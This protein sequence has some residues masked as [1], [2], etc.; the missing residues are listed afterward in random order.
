MDYSS[1]RSETHVFDNEGLR[2]W[3]A[4]GGGKELDGHCN[5]AKLQGSSTWLTTHIFVRQ[6]A[7]LEV[8]TRNDPFGAFET[9]VH[10]RG[11]GC[12]RQ[13]WGRRTGAGG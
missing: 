4:S 9:K 5:Q 2:A 7:V 12:I 11:V 10:L 1:V 3:I 6:S 13:R 8:C